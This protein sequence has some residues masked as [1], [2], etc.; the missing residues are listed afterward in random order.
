M[1]PK[2]AHV[3]LWYP[4]VGIPNRTDDQP[5]EVRVDLVDVRAANSIVIDYDFGRDGYRVRMSTIHEW[6]ADDEVMDEGLV[7][8]AFIPSWVEGAGPNDRK[9]A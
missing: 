2:T 4:R 3:D 8:V 5:T 9:E 7:E 6:D 1:T